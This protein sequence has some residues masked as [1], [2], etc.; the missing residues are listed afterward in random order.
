MN[1]CPFLHFFLVLSGQTGLG[2]YEPM[3]RSCFADGCC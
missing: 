2:G 1:G 3:P